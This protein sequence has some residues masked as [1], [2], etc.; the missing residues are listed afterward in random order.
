MQKNHLATYTT[1]VKAPVEKVWD[2]L[3]NPEMV[4][5]YFFG[6]DL[7]TDWKVGSPIFWRGDYE[8]KGYVDKGHV[9]EYEANRRLS[10]SYLSSWAQM[11]DKPEN[12][13][14]VIYEV[15]PVEEG[16]RLVITQSNYDAE[17]A[18]HSEINWASVMEGMKKLVE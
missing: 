7:D 4:K 17:R 18:R 3:T 1:V 15:S 13:L 11:E 2:A 5:K 12:Y 14:M 6:S 8:G 16:T 10:F 9:L